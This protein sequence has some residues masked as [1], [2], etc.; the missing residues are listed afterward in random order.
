MGF[1]INQTD[2]FLLLASVYLFKQSVIFCPEK[3]FSTGW[4]PQ[5][6]LM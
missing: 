5:I 3:N 6:K 1:G 2:D 4:I